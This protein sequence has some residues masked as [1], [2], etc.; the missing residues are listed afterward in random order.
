MPSLAQR[1]LDLR[2]L[3]GHVE[4][5]S[6]ALV[7]RTDKSSNGDGKKDTNTGTALVDPTLDGS[8]H[9]QNLLPRDPHPAALAVVRETEARMRELQDARTQAL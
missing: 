4:A 2:S 5:A 1:T 9:F 3:S 8:H 7:A 6:T